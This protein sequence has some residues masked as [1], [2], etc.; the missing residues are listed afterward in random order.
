MDWGHFGNW[1]GRRLYGFALTLCWSRMQ[2]VEF[3]QRQDMETMLNCMIHGFRFFGGV[4]ATVLTD[5]MKTWVVDR[6]DGQPRF[7]PK[8]LDFASYYG[9]VPRACHPYRPETKGKIESTIRFI[10]S[11]FWPGL[12]FDSLQELNRQALVWCEE[13]NRRVHGTTREIPL[14]RWTREGLAPLD[15]HPD[16]DTSYVSHRQVA[17]DCTFSYVGNRYSVPY[18]YAGKSVLVRQGLDSGAIRIFHQNQIVAEH[19]LGSGKGAMI[20]EPAHY[21]NLPCRSRAPIARSLTTPSE[22]VPGPG[23]GLHHP[24][25]EVEMRP[26]SIYQPFCEEAAYVATV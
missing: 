22:L 15:G 25:P 7:H 13:A 12:H 6:V 21:A 14:E 16:Y 3:T 18:S 19:Q 8:M 9:F 20:T 2:Y 4:T 24:I 26:L 5:N 10:K 17:K 23:V 1:A 11:S